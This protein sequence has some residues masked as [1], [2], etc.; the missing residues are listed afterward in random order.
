[1][2]VGATDGQVLAVD[3]L[4]DQDVADGAHSCL[5]GGG[6]VGDDGGH[7]DGLGMLDAAIDDV[8]ALHAAASRIQCRTDLGQHADMRAGLRALEFV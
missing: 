3:A 7:A 4:L 1:M 6:D 2:V 5:E 8:H